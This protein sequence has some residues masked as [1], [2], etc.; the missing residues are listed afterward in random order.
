[1]SDI[2]ATF[3]KIFRVSVPR[4]K[5]HDFVI[6]TNEYMHLNKDF[7]LC[8]VFSKSTGVFGLWF[9]QDIVCVAGGYEGRF[10]DGGWE[11]PLKTLRIFLS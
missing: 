9:L 8:Q 1:M 11:T 5:K 3:D 7:N 4:G 2:Y 10:I 6:N